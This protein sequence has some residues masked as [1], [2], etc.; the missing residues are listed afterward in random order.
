M[1]AS[2]FSWMPAPQGGRIREN[3]IGLPSYISLMYQVATSP[4]RARSSRD[5]FNAHVVRI[6]HLVQIDQDAYQRTIS[7]FWT[8]QIHGDVVTA[9]CL[10]PGD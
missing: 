9:H 4:I 10:T 7:D 8:P 2:S 3:L 5:Y 1:M 6:G